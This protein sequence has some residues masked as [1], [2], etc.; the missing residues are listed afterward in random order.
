M[1]HASTCLTC[2]SPQC[3]HNLYTVSRECITYTT[4]IRT[5]SPQI[6]TTNFLHLCTEQD[7]LEIQSEIKKQDDALDAIGDH[8]D[9]IM[10]MAQEMNQQLVQSDTKIDR[11]AVRNEVIDGD[12][13]A[14]QRKMKGLK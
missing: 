8:L 4:P 13:K 7:R 1:R 2:C 6:P 9:R 10:D 14:M 12:M 5:C 3:V 11:I